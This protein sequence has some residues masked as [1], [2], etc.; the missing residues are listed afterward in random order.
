ML[1]PSAQPEWQLLQA[2]TV[3]SVRVQQ[4]ESSQWWA[5]EQTLQLMCGL[6]FF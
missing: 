2:Q 6:P 1:S 3:M 4:L 5:Q